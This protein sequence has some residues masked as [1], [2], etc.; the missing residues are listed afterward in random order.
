MTKCG[1]KKYDELPAR[2]KL[3]DV[4]YIRWRLYRCINPHFFSNIPFLKYFFHPPI[5]EEI[6]QDLIKVLDFACELNT[7]NSKEVKKK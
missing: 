7:K 5:S 4:D 6:K 3:I 2:I 1:I